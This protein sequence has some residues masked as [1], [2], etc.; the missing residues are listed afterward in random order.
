MWGDLPSNAQ[1]IIQIH[2]LYLACDVKL[3]LLVHDAG[4]QL[5]LLDGQLQGQTQ[6]KDKWGFGTESDQL[7]GQG[8][9]E[10]LSQQT[11]E[12]GWVDVVL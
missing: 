5:T 4:V 3:L 8:G 2:N 11:L 12:S 10:V 6:Q 9:G 7:H 1:S